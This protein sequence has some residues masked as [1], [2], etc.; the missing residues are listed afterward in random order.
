M[1]FAT[2]DGL[3][4]YDGYSFT[5]YRHI[6]NDK[7]SLKD[8]NIETIAEDNKGNLWVGTGSG[9]S[10]YDPSSNSFINF[11]A[12][13]DNPSTLSNDDITSI[14]QDKEG[15]LWIGTYSGLNLIN[16]KTRKFKRFLYHKDQD[17]LPQRHIYAITEDQDGNL[18]L[19]TMGG[20][21]KFNYRTGQ[22][23]RY[24]HNAIPQSISSDNIHT[25]L[26]DRD[27]N[28]WIGT[29][30]G[31]LDRFDSAKGLFTHF[32]HKADQKGS[33]SDNNV[34]CLADA[35]N[36][37]L[38]V[39]TEK[40]LDIFDE[41]T[42]LFTLYDNQDGEGSRSINNILI[43]HGI[44]WVG[45]FDLGIIK[46]DSNIP[47][48]VHYY[49]HNNTAGELNNNVINAFAE[50]DNG[51]WI[52]TDGGGVNFLDKRTGEISHDKAVSGGKS[53][54]SLL[55]DS[56][57]RLWVGTY[58]NGLDIF[59]DQNKKIAHYAAGNSP[60]QISGNSVFAILEDRNGDIWTGIDDGGIN[61]IHNNRVIKRFK[62]DIKDTLH[63][64]SNDD[65]RA[66][67]QDKNGDIWIGT[68]DGLNL[69]D[70]SGH[71]FKHYKAYN[72]GLSNDAISSI[73]EDSRGNLWVGTMGGGLDLFNKKTNRFAVYNF[74]EG[75]VASTING[76]TEDS[77][78]FLWVS[79]GNGLIRFK[80][81]TKYQRH[82]TALNDLQGPEF[83]RGAV[84]LTQNKEILF[85][86]I[87]GF[88]II[89]PGYLP[90]NKYAPPVV[91][92]G[93]QLFNKEVQI[94]KG[95]ILKRS[96]SQ[97]NAIRLSY[98]Q[99]VFTIEYTALNYSFSQLNQ[100]AYKLD[101]F[102][103]EWNY[104]GKQRKATYTNLNPG[105]YVFEVKAANNDGIWNAKPATIEIIIVP[106][107]WMTWWFRI[108][109]ICFIIGLFYA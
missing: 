2:D 61:V 72:S 30:N 65:I 103:K 4:R 32:V 24:T 39:G 100:Y 17:Y 21:I 37:K 92:R 67:Y 28:V 23:K 63:S 101:G 18:L 62:Y 69:Y 94:G 91:F 42:G 78:G 35:G 73:F 75:I 38:W 84:L 86:G 109:A 81:G 99:S 15:H 79:T 31:G 44:M 41:S 83:A 25:L 48:F 45:V 53:I 12:N 96:V 60:G 77:E 82:F 5:V 107:F 68:F 93:F 80:P 98:D 43:D 74:A 54:L 106:P 26:K 9:L 11:T 13:K 87:N 50:N 55:E 64:L 27:G 58:D 102:E 36:R 104:V 66:L 51:F 34:L 70:H 71:G 88:N 76:I 56:H 19:G 22:F 97:T 89:D 95:S 8:N 85:G 20:L 52:G 33:I 57:K 14:Y 46:Y 40:G 105:H 90:M 3:N 6:A 59:D 108:V 29:A 16:A 7:H 49:K 1:W 47:S 10:L